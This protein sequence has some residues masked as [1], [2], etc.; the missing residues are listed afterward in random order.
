M[1]LMKKGTATTAQRVLRNSAWLFTAD[2]LAKVLALIIQVIAARY[3]GAKDFGV[4]SFA[5]SFAGILMIF[6]DSGINTFLAREISRNRERMGEY[7]DNAFF[8]KGALT[9][10]SVP[11]LGTM[12]FFSA[13]DDQACWVAWAIGLGLL[14][15][16]YAGI[17]IAAFRA[18]EQMRLVS[19]LSFTQ[20]ALFFVAGLTILLLGYKIVPL[21]LAFLCVAAVNLAATRWLYSAR[22]EWKKGGYSWSAIKDI[23]RHSA[24]LGGIILFSYIYFRID[25]IMLYYLRGEVE[26]GWYSAAFKLIEAVVL[27]IA[28]AQ[29]ALFPL[30]S[31]TFGEPN[32]RFCNIWKEAAR[33]MLLLGLPLGVATALLAP[34]LTQTLYGESF[35]AAGIA[36]QVMALAIPMLFLNNLANQVLVSANRAG[37]I[38]KTVTA[39]AAINIALNLILIPRLGYMG[40]AWA[41]CLTQGAVFGL[42]YK[43]I[44]RVCGG[45]GIFSLT[46]R[47]VAAVAGMALAM[48]IFFFL[49]LLPLAVFGMAA[50]LGLLA[51]LGTFTDRDRVILRGFLKN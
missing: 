3:I 24:P 16:G 23:F 12:I 48:R 49:P 14:L 5:F 20:R 40:A 45:I 39:G 19:V 18:L 25:G 4:F 37:D 28:A 8:L 51:L 2:A 10:A 31:R 22:M 38:L 42:Y 17:Y 21:S 32:D 44:G 26:T 1:T 34:R 35:G 13:L 47:P 6:A 9:L 29:D 11:I 43:I 15:N 41:I 50:Y 36:L 30:L 7:M 33:Y 27:L 46:W